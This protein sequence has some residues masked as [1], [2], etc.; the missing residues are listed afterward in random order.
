MPAT[1]TFKTLLE[2]VAEKTGVGYVLP[3]V[4]GTTTQFTLANAYGSGP[5]A[6]RFPRGSP[7]LTTAGTAIN[8]NTY[9]DNHTPSSGVTT[10]TP[11]PSNTWTDG[12]MFKLGMGIDHPDRVKEAINRA[13]TEDCYRWEPRPLTFVPDGDLQGTTVTDY[14]TAAANGTAAYVA[15]QIYPATGAADAFGQVGLNRVVQLTTSGGASTLTGN[16]IRW[17]ISTQQRLWYFQTAIRLVS[18]TGTAELKMR[19]NTNS[20]DIT[21]QVMRGNDSQTLTT[22]TLGDFMV[23]EG[24]FQM[25]TTG[26]EVAPQL[27]LDATALVAQMTPIVMFPL[28]V[29]TFPLPNRISAKDDVGNVMYATCLRNPGTIADL[30]LSDPLT[31]GS[32]PYRINSYGDHL[33]IRLPFYP[34]RAVYYE[35]AVFGTALTAM[36]DTTIFAEDYV[37]KWAKWEL[38]RYL[39]E[40]DPTVLDP[41]KRAVTS[42]WV[43]KANAAKRGAETS[44]HE[45]DPLMVYGRR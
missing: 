1:T 41:N 33:T 21:L 36:T 32:E 39:A 22:T 26:A 42:P 3:T 15:A 6:N 30:V 17:P 27:T 37:V 5:W 16:G 25:P 24:T 43:R 38:Y 45:P 18:G 14:W 19:D 44:D 20:A 11:A 12:I 9:V 40:H 28:N 29:T 34:T 31:I 2:E 23:C 7:I 10:I 4:T 8:E 35:E 13:L